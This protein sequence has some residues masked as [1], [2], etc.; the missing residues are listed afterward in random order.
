MLSKFS[1]FY[2]AVV[3]KRPL[4]AT[5]V[6]ILIIIAVGSAASRFRLDASADSL[7]LEND[8][9]PEIFPLDQRALRHNRFRR[10]QLFTARG[11]DR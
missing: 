4:V 2:E 3:L 6:L 11:A 8:Q 10:H 7:L 5:V 1:R 9:G